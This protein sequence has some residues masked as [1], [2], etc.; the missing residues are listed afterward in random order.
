M[1]AGNGFL[2]F[3]IPCLSQRKS[4]VLRR[5]KELPAVLLPPKRWSLVSLQI[6]SLRFSPARRLLCSTQIGQT[7]PHPGGQWNRGGK[8]RGESE[9]LRAASFGPSSATGSTDHADTNFP[10][11]PNS[12]RDCY[13]VHPMGAE[14]RFAVSGQSGDH[15]FEDATRTSGPGAPPR[16]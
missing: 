4:S 16:D 2:N 9:K 13:H 3:S 15:P 6:H 1:R 14:G 12:D 11:R 5:T 7:N 8:T 10:T